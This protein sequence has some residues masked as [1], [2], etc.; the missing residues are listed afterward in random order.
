M[1][2]WTEIE[3]CAAAFAARRRDSAVW[4][5]YRKAWSIGDK[6]ACVVDLMRL[7]QAH[8]RKHE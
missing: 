5:A 8:M 1:L 4:E 6:D 2:S 3:P 7:Y